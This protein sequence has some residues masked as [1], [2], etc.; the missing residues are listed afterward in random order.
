[1]LRNGGHEGNGV[2]FTPVT[3]GLQNSSSL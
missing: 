1:L 3:F 2:A